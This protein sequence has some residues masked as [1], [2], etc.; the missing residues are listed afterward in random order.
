MIE[1]NDSAYM[2]MLLFDDFA[3]CRKIHDLLKD[4]RGRP[5]TEIG[6]LDVPS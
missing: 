1:H 6:S 5:I 2:G 3:F 4:R